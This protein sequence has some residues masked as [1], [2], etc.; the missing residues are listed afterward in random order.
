MDGRGREQYAKGRTVVPPHLV[1][2]QVGRMISLAG[3]NLTTRRTAAAPKGDSRGGG[4]LDADAGRGGPGN[5]DRE[6]ACR[7]AIALESSGC[8][9]EAVRGASCGVDQQ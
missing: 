8:W 7:P 6:E 3:D 1:G 9:A 2:T 4:G 5:H